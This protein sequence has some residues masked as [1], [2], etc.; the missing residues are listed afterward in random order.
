MSIPSKD[1]GLWRWQLTGGFPFIDTD[2]LQS[3]AQLSVRWNYLSIHSQA[4]A[5]LKLGIAKEF[6]PT[7]NKKCNNLSMFG[8]KLTR[9]KI[10]T[11]MIT[12][13]GLF[14]YCTL[15]WHNRVIIIQKFTCMLLSAEYPL[16]SKYELPVVT[17]VKNF[18]LPKESIFLN[19]EQHQ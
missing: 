12:I 14:A 18:V 8:L 13:N 5:A 4:G 11:T 2:W 1:Y 7:L 10:C 6:H 9:V 3:H 16:I 15:L 19:R 17:P